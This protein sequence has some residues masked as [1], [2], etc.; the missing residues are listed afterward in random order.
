MPKEEREG[1]GMGMSFSYGRGKGEHRKVAFELGFATWI[2][3]AIL[4][5]Y[6]L[7]PSWAKG[8]RW[9]ATVAFA[10]HNLIFGCYL[11]PYKG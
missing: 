5:A 8:Q 11:Q 9:S 4:V 1:G 7:L 6:G 10:M 2:F 3:G